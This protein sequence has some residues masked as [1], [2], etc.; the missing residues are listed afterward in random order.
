MTKYFQ[1]DEKMN[2]FFNTHRGYLMSICIDK[3]DGTERILNGI[4]CVSQKGVPMISEGDI[5]VPELKQVNV[6]KI[7]WVMLDGVRHFPK[8]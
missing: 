8:G 4:C 6:N 1:Y 7:K 5:E 3:A 2:R